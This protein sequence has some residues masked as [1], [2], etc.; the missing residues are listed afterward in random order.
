M[1][2]LRLC[3][4]QGDATVVPMTPE[5]RQ[6]QHSQGGF[7]SSS[8]CT[9]TLPTCAV[10]L[11]QLIDPLNPNFAGRRAATSTIVG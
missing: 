7:N 10:P 2:L 3:D 1:G 11:M 6:Q 8:T 9:R 5:Q 4:P